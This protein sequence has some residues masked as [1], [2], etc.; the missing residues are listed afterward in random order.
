LILK[1]ADAILVEPAPW[2]GLAD[3]WAFFQSPIREANV[4]PIWLSRGHAGRRKENILTRKS[5][6]DPRMGRNN[7]GKRSGDHQL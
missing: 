1:T 3:G 6:L 2:A 4:A 5:F 7:S